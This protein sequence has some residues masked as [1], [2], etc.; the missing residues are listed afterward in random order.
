MG[1]ILI[2][3]G[4]TGL[5]AFSAAWAIQNFVLQNQREDGSVTGF[6][7]RSAGFGLE[8]IVLIGGMGLVI[9][10]GTKLTHV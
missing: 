7:P 2:G 10:F 4:A 9:Y 5:I 6:V 8:E 3:V 1:K